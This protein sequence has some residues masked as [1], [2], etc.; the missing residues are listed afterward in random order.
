VRYGTP[1]IV[2]RTT[3]WL[4]NFRRIL[5]RHERFLSVYRAFSLVA[6]VIFALRTLRK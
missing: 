5:V 6:C 2:E 1:W 3:A 4:Q